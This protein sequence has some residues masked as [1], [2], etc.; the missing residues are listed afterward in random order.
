MKIACCSICCS[1]SVVQFNK[2]DVSDE[3][4]DQKLSILTPPDI[5]N[6]TKTAKTADLL[7]EK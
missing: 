7:P 1:V 3:E 6:K 2:M 4:S 5:L